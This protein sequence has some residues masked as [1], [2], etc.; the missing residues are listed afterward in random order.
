MGTRDFDY[1]YEVL[2]GFD[3]GEEMPDYLVEKVESIY[4]EF[5]EKM[6]ECNYT[7]EMVQLELDRMVDRL[8]ELEDEFLRTNSKI[9]DLSRLAMRGTLWYI[10]KWF[11]VDIDINLALRN[12]RW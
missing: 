7:E 6:E 11:E 9:D 10:L 2:H 4:E 8:N 12:K 3:Y 5:I 1:N